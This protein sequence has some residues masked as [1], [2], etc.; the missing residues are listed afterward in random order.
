M[1][2]GPGS[3]RQMGFKARYRAAGAFDLAPAVTFLC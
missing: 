2:D 1:E 3:A